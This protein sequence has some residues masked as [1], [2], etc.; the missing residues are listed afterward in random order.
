MNVQ[1]MIEQLFQVLHVL[2]LRVTPAQHR[3]FLSKVANLQRVLRQRNPRLKQ[4]PRHDATAH[5]A[6]EPVIAEENSAGATEVSNRQR[7]QTGSNYTTPCTAESSHGSESPTWRN[8][9]HDMPEDHDTRHSTLEPYR[10]SDEL[11]HAPLP[12]FPSPVP[13]TSSQLA[14]PA[15]YM[16]TPQRSES[17][18]IDRPCDTQCDTASV[19]SVM[20]RSSTSCDDRSDSSTTEYSQAIDKENTALEQ[21]C[22][23]PIHHAITWSD[24]SFTDVLSQDSGSQAIRLLLEEICSARP[25]QRLRDIL[26]DQSNNDCL[27]P[28]NGDVVKLCHTAGVAATRSMKGRLTY[29]S[30][31]MEFYQHLQKEVDDLAQL[32]L[33][34]RELRRRYGDS[35]VLKT[36]ETQIRDIAPEHRGDSATSLSLV[37]HK[38]AQL[39]IESG[40]HPGRDFKTEIVGLRKLYSTGQCFTALDKTLMPYISYLWPDDGASETMAHMIL[41]EADKDAAALVRSLEALLHGLSRSLIGEM[42][43][44]VDRVLRIDTTRTLRIRTMSDQQ[45]ELCRFN[46]EA[47]SQLFAEIPSTDILW[48]WPSSQSPVEVP[49]ADL[50]AGAQV[51]LQCSQMPDNQ[52]QG[53]Y[54]WDWPSPQDPV[55][56]PSADIQEGAQIFLQCQ[57]PVL[58]ACNVPL[59]QCSQMPDN[60]DQRNGLWTW[61]S[62]QDPVSSDE[63]H[64]TQASTF[65]SMSQ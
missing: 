8:I 17:P 13:L 44:R 50:Q 60:Q 62:P 18:S 43:G 14:S 51:F 16:P 4:K 52:D 65:W 54:L 49:S 56:V 11:L 63:H 39:V 64:Q 36:I 31:A 57:E 9:S 33:C 19:I 48:D 28:W 25:L 53:N 27:P 6:I 41:K 2:T 58:R 22:V 23:D 24:P 45:I 61:P 10:Q 3:L 47:F 1:H 7:S 20:R 32:K 30:L 29:R 26:N 35:K 12:F 59:D 55:E 40:L 38:Y 37:I 42:L 5:C 15:L 21:D 46:C 34:R